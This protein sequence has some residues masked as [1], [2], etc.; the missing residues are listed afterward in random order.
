MSETFSRPRRP[1]M[2]EVAALA[3]VSLATVSR[4][5]NGDGKVA[6]DRAERVHDAVALL[7]YRRDASASNLRRADRVSASIGVVFEDVA[8]PFQ[9]AVLRGLETVVRERGLLTLVG[10]SDDDAAR[11]RELAEAFSSR[12]IDGLVVLPAGTRPLLPARRPRRGRGDGVRRPPAGAARGRR[13][14]ERQRRRRGRGDRAPDRARAPPDRLPRRRAAHLHGRRAAARPSRGARAPRHRART[15]RSCGPSCATA[16]GGRGRRRAARAP[17]A[18]DRAPDARRT[19]SPWARSG[20]CARWTGIT[21][22][23]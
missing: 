9:A 5:L 13:R 11:E 19:S 4:V 16:R 8:N 15:P 18:A 23:R 10:S 7:G 22:S 21:P 2:R 17:R 6:P 12:R 3:G 20:G 14:R 1:T